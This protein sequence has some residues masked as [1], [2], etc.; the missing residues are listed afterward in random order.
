[1]REDGEG[2]R[3]MSEEPQDAEFRPNYKFKCQNCGQ[4]PTVDVYVDGKLEYLSEL[5]GC[6]MWGEAACIDPENW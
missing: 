3:A 4:T 6:C 2:V 1:M 5:C